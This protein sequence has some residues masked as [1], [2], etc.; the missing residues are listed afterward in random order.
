[1]PEYE[2]TDKSRIT[3]HDLFRGEEEDGFVMVGRK[4]IGSYVS[5]PVEALEV[6][7]LLN[8]EKTV[9]EVKHFTEKKYGEDIGVTEFIQEMIAAEMVYRVD[10]VTIPTTSGLQKD[11][12]SS[13]TGKHVQW[14]FST[15]A[16]VFYGALAVVCLVIFAVAPQYIPTPRDFFFHPWYSVAMVVWFFFGWVVV[17]YHEIGHLCAAKAVGIEGYFSLSNRLLFIVAQTTLGNIWTIP[18][19]K[20]YIVYFAGIAWDIVM[21]FILLMLLI[22]S[23]HGG[24]TLSPLGYAFVKSVMFAEVWSII[25]QF[26][27]NMQT[28]IYFVVANYFK[29]KSLLP[30][31]QA[32]IKNFLST[33]IPVTRTDFSNTPPSEM[34]AVKWYTLFYFVGTS[35]TLASFFLRSLPLFILQVER[36][37]NGITAGYT[38]NPELYTDGVVLVCVAV[39]NWSLFGYLVLR[40]RWGKLKK[41]FRAFISAR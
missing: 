19:R 27:F 35:V 41:G 29:C 1:M 18:R 26:R 10:E 40:P 8:T 12:V 37:V 4:D 11:M 5:V 28:D 6:I 39:F 15:Y 34:K 17:A 32:Y 22:L 33:F 7:D 31:A 21:I 24:V 25:W 36:A 20:R 9:G 2:I 14:M 13:L 23:D 3:F 16:W 38:A 30:D